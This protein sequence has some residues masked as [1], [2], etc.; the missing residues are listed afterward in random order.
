MP[1]PQ[2]IQDFQ[3]VFST[4]LNRPCPGCALYCI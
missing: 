2:K 3:D 4:H 1:Y